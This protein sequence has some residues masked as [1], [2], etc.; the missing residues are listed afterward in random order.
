MSYAIDKKAA[1]AIL[2]INLLIQN[3]LSTTYLPAKQDKTVEVFKM[4]I[5]TIS[6]SALFRYFLSTGGVFWLDINR[7]MHYNPQVANKNDFFTIGLLTLENMIKH[8]REITNEVLTRNTDHALRGFISDSKE[9]LH[10]FKV[11]T[12]KKN[13]LKELTTLPPMGEFPGGS[14]FYNAENKLYWQS[15]PRLLDKEIPDYHLPPTPPSS[16]IGGRYRKGLRL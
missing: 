5:D 15:A 2:G 12:Q 8:P 10:N 11:A 4:M 3:V 7:L 6:D 14:D 9:F 16:P 1:D 13:T